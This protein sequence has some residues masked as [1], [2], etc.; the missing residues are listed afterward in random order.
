MN[1]KKRSSVITPPPVM[2]PNAT[3]DG[4]T[5]VAEAV[6]Q[7]QLIKLIRKGAPSVP[8]AERSTDEANRRVKVSLRLQKSLVRRYTEAAAQRLPAIPGNSWIIEAII[9]KLKKDGY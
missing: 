2:E 7:E 6:R 4:G 1:A 8:P 9:E 3:I 5:S